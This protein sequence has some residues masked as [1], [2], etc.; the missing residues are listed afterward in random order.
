M[1]AGLPP[2][3]G[4]LGTWATGIL[5]SVAEDEPLP[6]KPVIFNRVLN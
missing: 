2:R 3:S 1:L 6:T 5:G 4:Y